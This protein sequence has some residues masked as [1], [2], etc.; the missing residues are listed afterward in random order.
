MLKRHIEPP[1]KPRMLAEQTAHAH[2]HRQTVG[3]LLRRK[4]PVADAG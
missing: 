4:Q 3:D 1:T 2:R